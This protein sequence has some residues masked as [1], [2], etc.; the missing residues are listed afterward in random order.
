[1]R[2]RHR[3]GVAGIN[4]KREARGEVTMPEP[5]PDPDALL[6]TVRRFLDALD[7]RQHPHALDSVLGTVAATAVTAW[8]R[9]EGRPS[10]ERL[11]AAIT[12]AAELLEGL[13]VELAGADQ[14][15]APRGK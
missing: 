8:A 15:G 4:P 12:A 1:M 6:A 3:F 11:L 7:A 10:P 9:A 14:G 13:A 2:A 5:E